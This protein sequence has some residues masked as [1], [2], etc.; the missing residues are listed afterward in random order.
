MLFEMLVVEMYAV[1][2]V[3]SVPE[4][5]DR[6]EVL[7]REAIERAKTECPNIQIVIANAEQQAEVA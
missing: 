4:E 5:C 3:P 1:A 6:A 7:I 2:L